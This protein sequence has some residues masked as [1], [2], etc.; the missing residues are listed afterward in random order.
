M[1]LPVPI[2]TVIILVTQTIPKI[3]VP[4][5][6]VPKYIIP[7]KRILTLTDLVMPVTYVPDMMIILIQMKMGFQTAVIIYVVMS[8]MT[9]VLMLEMPYS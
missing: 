4:M 3:P 6:T 2:P 5:I 1:V 7:I 9:K 8:T